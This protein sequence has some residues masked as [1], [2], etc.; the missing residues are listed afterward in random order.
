M[1]HRTPDSVHGCFDVAFGRPSAHSPARG[2]S[3]RSKPLAITE[4][5]AEKLGEGGDISARIN[6]AGVHGSD[7][8]ARGADAVA[9]DD[10]CSTAGGFID[11]DRKRFV[12]R[13]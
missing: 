1:F 9:G 11:D 3:E 4:Q 13:G 6:Q 8:V 12:F 7:Q 2:V 10:G 5:S